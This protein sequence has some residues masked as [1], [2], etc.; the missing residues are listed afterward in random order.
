[1]IEFSV[2]MKAAFVVLELVLCAWWLRLSGV[3][4]LR[5]PE[6]S[7]V[8]FCEVTLRLVYVPF[9]ESRLCPQLP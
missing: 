1:M 4:L 9:E 3:V 6:V 2:L 5:R 7:R 8:M